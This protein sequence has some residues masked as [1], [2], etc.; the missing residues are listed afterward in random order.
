MF[1]GM[2]SYFKVKYFNPEIVHPFDSQRFAVTSGTLQ[3]KRATLTYWCREGARPEL[4]PLIN[5]H[6]NLQH[7]QQSSPMGAN[8]IWLLFHCV[9]AKIA[10]KFV[11]ALFFFVQSRNFSGSVQVLLII[12]A[13]WC[14]IKNDVKDARQE[15]WGSKRMCC[16]ALPQYDLIS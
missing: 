11:S 16:T 2:V 3:R 4:P 6:L 12:L 9:D 5:V 7:F 14:L 15:C 13:L 10:E 1:Y 8:S